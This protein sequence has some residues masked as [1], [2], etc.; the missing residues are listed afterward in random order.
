LFVSKIH[1]GARL[2][3]RPLSLPLLHNVIP[4][5]GGESYLNWPKW[6]Y[7]RSPGLQKIDRYEPVVF[8]YPEGDTI[9]P[10]TEYPDQYYNQIRRGQSRE[11]LL[12]NN[13]IV[14]RPVDKRDHYIKRCV[15][16]PGDEIQVKDRI[17]YVNGK[18][19]PIFAGLQYMYYIYT[20]GPLNAWKDIERDL[21]V[22]FQYYRGEPYQVGRNVYQVFLKYAQQDEL[23]QKLKKLAPVSQRNELIS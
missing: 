12:A 7:H 20:K 13:E 6:G 5:I 11:R 21:D 1:Y 2:P 4:G 18:Q 15:G 8:N 10:D 22:S 3:M 16:L 19:A 17:L 14:V 9:F 23:I